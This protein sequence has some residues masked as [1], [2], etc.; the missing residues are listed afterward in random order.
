MRFLNNKHRA[1]GLK[2]EE[3]ACEFL[4]TLGFEIMERN[5]LSKF[6]EIDIIA[7]KKGVLHFIEV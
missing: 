5:F 4:K 3:E 2:A 1:K 7:L 6:V